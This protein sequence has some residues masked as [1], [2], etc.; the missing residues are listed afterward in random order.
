MKRQSVIGNVAKD[1]GLD[2]RTL[3]SRKARVDSEGTRKRNCDINL[4][5]GD[6]VTSERM[7]RESLCGKKPSCVVKVDLVLENPLELHRM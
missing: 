1:L 6:L 7:D 5:T 3:S 4:S 2:L